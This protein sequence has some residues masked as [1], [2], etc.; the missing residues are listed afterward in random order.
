IEDKKNLTAFHLACKFGHEEEAVLLIEKIDRDKLFNLCISDQSGNIL[1]LHLA[2]R[3][4]VEKFNIIHNVLK[5]LQNQDDSKSQTSILKTN[6]LDIIS[7]KEDINR[8][9]ILEISIENNHLKIVELFLNDFKFNS[10]LPNSLNGNYPI[11]IAAK[12]G[13]IEMLNLLIKYKTS[14]FRLNSNSENPLHIAA[15]NNK[16]K[17]IREYLKY[18]KFLLVNTHSCELKNTEFTSS[19]FIPCICNCDEIVD[20]QNLQLSIRQRDE[21][22]FTP[23]MQAIS[24]GN[25]RCIDE[26]IN[27][28]Y[29][30]FDSKDQNGQSIFHLCTEFNN[31]EALKFFLQLDLIPPE[32]IYSKDNF[33]N[34]ILHTSCFYGNLEAIKLIVNK[35]YDSNNS[36]EQILYCKN[37]DGQTCFHIACSKGYFNIVE[38]FLKDKKM[39]QF[40][41]FVDVNSNTSL[42]MA[43]ENGHSSIVSLL[44]DY[45]ADVT[46]KNEEN[47]TALDLSCRLGFFE[48]SK[49][50]INNCTNFNER[51]K[52]NEYP[53]HTACYEGAYEVVKLLLHKGVPIDQLNS[54]N[55]NCLEIAIQQGHREVIRVLLDDPNWKKLLRSNNRFDIDNDEVS[56]DNSDD[57]SAILKITTSQSTQDFKP[58]KTVIKHM[59]NPELIRLFDYKMWDIFNIILDKCITEKEIDFTKIDP[60]IRSVS[61]HP[62]MLIARSGQEG[63][64]KH[65]A[66]RTLLHLKWRVIPR[67]AFYFN[68]IIYII[69]MSLFSL[70]SIELSK[71]GAEKMS[72][73]NSSNCTEF[74][75]NIKYNLNTEIFIILLLILAFQIVKE[76]FQIF[77]LDGLTYFLSLQNLVELFTYVTSILSLFSSNYYMQSAYASIAVLFAFIVFPLFTQK[78]KI[79]GLYV[80]AFRRTL[81]NSAKFFPIFLILFTGFILSFRIRSN[82]NVSYFNSTSYSLIRTFTM[83][84]GEL[85]TSRMGLYN[86]SLPNYIIYFMFIG[87]MGIIVLNLFVGIAVGEIKTVLD[88][89]DIQQTSMRI[90][91]VLKVQSALT[92]FQNTCLGNCLN[93]QF[94]KYSLINENKFVRIKNR[95][96]RNAKNLLSS[97]EHTIK[98]SDPQKRLEDS[99]SELSRATGDQ[100]KSLRF[101]FSNQI[102]DCESRLSNAQRRLQDSLIELSNKTNEQIE[103][104]RREST[105]TN[106][107]LKNKLI[108]T[109]DTLRDLIQSYTEI[110]NQ[111]LEN[112]NQCFNSQMS[113][114]ETKIL[115]LNN[116][117]QSILVNLSKKTNFQFESIKE[118]SMNQAYNI[119][120]VVINSQKLIDDSIFNLERSN[121]AFLESVEEKYLARVDKLEDL[122]SK[123]LNDD[124]FCKNNKIF[125]EI[126]SNSNEIMKIL[127]N[128]TNDFV[129]LNKKVDLYVKK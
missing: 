56:D 45:G 100:I 83:V 14:I 117:I 8:Q 101:G 40:L 20:Y 5:K 31:I 10:E 87:L 54:Q 70:Y 99:F 91:F 16:Y 39:L 15:L 108:E 66:T 127:V 44:L 96:W 58:K 38:Y 67:C 68:L 27:D 17:F 88:E 106:L 3:N 93:M 94:T 36:L 84:V 23:L 57:E 59:D 63:L 50:I 118:Y 77:F 60:P 98:L 72:Q 18:E 1:P 26:L 129:N 90:I 73:N 105:L 64:L 85:D 6:Y 126:N 28:R 4:K 103:E 97:K 35:L 49:N 79:F 48:I 111:E 82:F 32:I 2:C 86:D 33:E 102:T 46:I 37:N 62:L 124:Y 115:G 41:D 116:K 128:L 114:S 61:Q 74:E 21:K 30:E 12:N 95:L 24:C 9:N 7:K 13:S 51:E 125:T 107:E 112:T 65:Q 43:T 78:L 81:A 75:K 123:I 80:V 42:H 110:T 25:Q 109:Q 104:L 113:D 71:F 119:K 11:H 47:I 69:F 120:S 121:K 89:A 34:T 52:L 55:K 76:L 29:I 122:L 53:L 19:K 92:L 22:F